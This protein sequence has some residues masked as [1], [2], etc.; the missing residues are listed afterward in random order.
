MWC[1]MRRKEE[2]FSVKKQQFI[3]SE[4]DDDDDEEKKKKNL[5]QETN[6]NLWKLV[7]HTLC[8]HHHRATHDI[9]ISYLKGRNNKRRKEEIKKKKSSSLWVFWRRFFSCLLNVFISLS[10]QRFDIKFNILSW[11]TLR[12]VRPTLSFIFFYLLLHRLLCVTLTKARLF[13]FWDNLLF[14][15][16]K[17]SNINLN[18]KRK[19]FHFIMKL[20]ILLLLIIKPIEFLNDYQLIYKLSTTLFFIWSWKI[21]FTM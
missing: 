13:D 14:Y 6:T 7:L 5:S 1:F 18:S 3:P 4:W 10:L 8:G 11:T 17:N 16:F 12:L 21:A 15:V 19:F 20:L 9:K 2:F